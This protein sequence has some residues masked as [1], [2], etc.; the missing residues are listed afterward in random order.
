MMVARA[1][2]AIANYVVASLNILTWRK[3]RE[4]VDFWA[5]VAWLAS[6]TLWVW[7]AIFL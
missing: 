2:I 5:S 4:S 1:M 6:G 7:Q 3:S